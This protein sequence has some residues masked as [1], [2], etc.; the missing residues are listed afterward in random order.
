[1]ADNQQLSMELWWRYQYLRDNGHLKYV[2]KAAKCD[3]FF[4]GIQWDR[5]ALDT[6]HEQNRPALTINKILSTIAN[7]T[8]EQ[9]FNRTEIGFRP[10][11]KGATEGTAEALT[12]VFKQIGDANQLSWARTDVYLDGLI[13][14]RGFYD[15]RLDFSDSLQGDARIEQLNPKNV[16]IDSDASHYD[17]D[18]WNDVI[19]TKW[20][21]LDDIELIYGKRWRKKLEGNATVMAPYE[22]DMQDWD[23]DKFGDNNSP[24]QAH[25]AYMDETTQPLM[26]VVRVLE[27]Q[28]RKLDKREHFVHLPT[29]E[30]RSIPDGW[31]REDI[32]FYL[33]KN[34][35]YSTVEKLAPRIRWTVGAGMEIM[36]DEWSPYNHFT[37]VPFFPYFRRGTTI[38]VVE[39]LL[40]PQEL[41]NKV[42]S[43]E[44]HVIN[45]T[46]N[47][48]WKL[49]AGSLQNMSVA[50]LEAK[51]AT[52]GV[53]LELDEV[54][55][56]EKILPNQVPSG[57]DR[58]SFKAEEHI[59]TISGLPDANTGF[60]REDV[61]A[62]ALKANQVTSS[63]NFA[64]VQDN[65]NRTDFFLARSLLDVVQ[66]Y[67]TEER[68]LHITTDP[69][70]RQTEEFTVNEV[71][72]EGDILN[73]LTIGEYDIVVTNQPER[74]TLEDSTFA[75]AAEMRKEL[76][77]AIPDD[78]LIKSSRLPNKIEVV[79]AINAEKNSEAAQEQQRIDQAR[80]VAEI[81]Q[82]ESGTRRDD[83]DS[84]VKQ[85]KAQQD[86]VNLTRPIDPEAQLRVEADIAKSKY[87][88]DV[89]AQIKREQMDSDLQIAILKIRSAEKVAEKSAAAAAKTAAVSKPAAAKPAA[90]KPA[91]KKAAPK[92]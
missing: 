25:S 8:G 60:A 26:R 38:G 46:A 72:P 1:M 59:K 14:S 5:K 20:L 69:L 57:L 86:A 31:E 33:Q 32:S 43:Q 54:T 87:Q 41:L 12:K 90:K 67:Y 62:K 6:L 92:K 56:A 58:V 83:A 13:G 89:D 63:A 74:D 29:G 24:V 2:A 91:A 81:K 22:Y 52:T 15:V 79:E 7:I 82:I 55:D 40:G 70:Q 73:D 61:S 85:V 47:S 49:K 28:W 64:M 78:V 18:K 53:V 9:I 76:G 48:G 88:V 16:L 23:Q 71:T 11:K 19:T 44:L 21:S 50:E 77:V 65:L 68:L 37:V 80:Q 39:N 4:Q 45:T 34:Q 66:R 3:N 42:S 17:P 84:V 10:N 30:I 51:G 75:Q 35:E 36:H 27:R